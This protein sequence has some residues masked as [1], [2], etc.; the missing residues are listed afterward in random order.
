[1]HVCWQYRITEDEPWSFYKNVTTDG[2]REFIARLPLNDTSGHGYWYN[3]ESAIVL[4]AYEFLIER[5]EYSFGR[6][7]VITGPFIVHFKR[8][9]KEV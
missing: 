8:T 4:D 6:N 2:I 7:R 3:E 9:P 5:M 1:M